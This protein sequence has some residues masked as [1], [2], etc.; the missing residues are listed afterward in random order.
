[1]SVIIRLREGQVFD[2]LSLPLRGVLI[3]IW[4]ADANGIYQVRSEYRVSEKADPAFQ[5]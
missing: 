3:E 5:G 2:G 1:M 4:Q